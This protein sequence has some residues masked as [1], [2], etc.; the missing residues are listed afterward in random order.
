MIATQEFVVPKSMPMTSPAS[1]DRHLFIKFPDGETVVARAPVVAVPAPRDDERS[2]SEAADNPLRTL[3]CNAMISL[4]LRKD[5]D[6]L[7]IQ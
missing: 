4:Y 5:L 1:E 7:Y 3:N 6:L 2:D